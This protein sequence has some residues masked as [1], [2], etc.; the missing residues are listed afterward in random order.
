MARSSDL[1]IIDIGARGYDRPRLKFLCTHRACE[2]EVTKRMFKSPISDAS[3]TGIEEAA[4]HIP[5]EHGEWSI[6]MQWTMETN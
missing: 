2:T 5:E 1:T 6:S 4:L 3:K